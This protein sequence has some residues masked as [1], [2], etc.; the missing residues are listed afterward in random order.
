LRLTVAVVTWRPDL[1]LFRRSLE[2]LAAALLVARGEGR[3]S[4][5]KLFVIDNGPDEARSALT[6]VLASWP[7]EAGEVELIAGHGNVGYG[8]A[9]N[10]VL[11]RLDSDLHLVMNPD[12]EVDPAAISKAIE[13]LQLHS[14][15]G[16]MAPAAFGPDGARQFLCKRM[17]TPGV[18]FLRGFAPEFL[19]RPFAKALDHYEM[20]D[21]IGEKF[22]AGV[23]IVSGC[24]MLMRTALFKKLRGF[25]PGYFLYFED[26][27]LSLRAGREATNAYEPAVR[28][29]HHGGNAGR[30]GFAH[31][32]YFLRSAWR[33]FL[34]LP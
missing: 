33:F 2:T 29:V 19:K 12:V 14:E 3:L 10:L 11:D 17:P 30:K 22:V 26:F 20:R 7:R 24:F 16:L 28:I 31:V 1:A 9:N 23:P 5:A 32:R 21:V 15:V 25:D 18:L 6:P 8:R 27:D 13:S 4:H 34:K